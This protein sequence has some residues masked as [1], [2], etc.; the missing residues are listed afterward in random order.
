ML[1]VFHA[2]SH[3]PGDGGNLLATLIARF[4]LPF[5]RP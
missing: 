1:W 5:Q 4:H 2:L 3:C